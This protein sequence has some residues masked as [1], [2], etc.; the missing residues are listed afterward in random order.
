MRTI[1]RAMV[2]V[3]GIGLGCWP[4]SG[5]AA[6]PGAPAV[7]VSIMPIHSLI[8]SVMQGVGEPTL[9]V[10]GAASPHTASLRPSEAAALQRADVIFW[11]GADMETFLA[12][13][14]AA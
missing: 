11:I 10:K 7:V 3:I 4:A 1:G 13:P 9:L 2:L 14:L 5:R 6:D 12:K 8:A